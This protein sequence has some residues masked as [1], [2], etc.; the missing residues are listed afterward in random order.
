MLILEGTTANTTVTMTP[1]PVINTPRLVPSDS[2]KVFDGAA[3]VILQFQ[4]SIIFYTKPIVFLA[5]KKSLVRQ[6]MH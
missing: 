5:K 2:L 1:P 3:L 6:N 4:L